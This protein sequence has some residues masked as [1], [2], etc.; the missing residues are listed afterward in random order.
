MASRDKNIRLL[1]G[2]L[3]TLFNSEEFN[4]ALMILN[5][6]LRTI[7]VCGFD[8]IWSLTNKMYLTLYGQTRCNFSFILGWL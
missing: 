7:T 6:K 1:D 4:S 3:D 8:H 2:R 5:K